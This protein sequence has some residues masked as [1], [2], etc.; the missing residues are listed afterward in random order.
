MTQTLSYEIKDISLAEQGKKN[1]EWAQKDMPV[2]ANITERFKREKPFAGL[3]LTACV[4]VTK[5]TAALCIAMKEGG[6]DAVLAASNPLS[7]QDDVAA[8]LVKY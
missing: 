6:A 1:I 2:L 8:A 5:E 4:H 3:R 7:T